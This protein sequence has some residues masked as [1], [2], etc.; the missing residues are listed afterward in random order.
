VT[1]TS[2]DEHQDEVREALRTI[3][4]D[5]DFGERALSNAQVMA[6]LLKDYLP[7]A[8]RE[9]SVLVSAAEAGV[10]DTLRGHVAEGMD[11]ATASSLAA[12]AFAARAPYQ[13]EAC[14]WVVREFA[15]AMGLTPTPPRVSRRTG[16]GA[17]GAGTVTEDVETDTSRAGG[18]GSSG[19]GGGT[20]PS[21]RQ[22]PKT[23]IAGGAGALGVAVVV[24]AVVATHSPGPVHHHGRTSPHAPAATHHHVASGV[25]PVSKIVSPDVNHCRD[26]SSGTL[27]GVTTSQLCQTAVPGIALNV[28]QFD[29]AAD[30]QAG[31]S[32]L[33]ASLGWNPATAGPGCPPPGTDTRGES[34]WH[35]NVN[36]AY[37]PRP[38]QNLECFLEPRTGDPVYLWTLPTQRVILAGVDTA[39]GATFTNLE[40]WWAGFT[41]G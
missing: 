29:T 9:T 8:P 15:V 30:Y 3:V 18:G 31:L 13:P 1:A 21:R 25:E 27:R 22:I 35:S 10:A 2:W 28:L 23:W 17:G 7:D 14:D 39:P 16:T 37:P 33:N 11:V 6:N 38:G 12:S 20:P 19:E 40:D 34:G 41:Y 26:Q 32:D 36:P 5:P 24:I 4:S